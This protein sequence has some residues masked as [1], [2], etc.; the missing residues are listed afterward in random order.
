[1]CFSLAT[2][3]C[4][5]LSP[6]KLPSPWPVYLGC[7]A[8]PTPVS[9]VIMQPAQYGNHSLVSCKN[10]ADLAR[11]HPKSGQYIAVEHGSTASYNRLGQITA[12]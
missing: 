11:C 7:S 8:D 1:M 12:N 10:L 9:L 4:K 3:K 6:L 2:V 5:I